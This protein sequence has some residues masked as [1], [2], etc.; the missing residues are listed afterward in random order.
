MPAGQALVEN[1]ARFLECGL[2]LLVHILEMTRRCSAPNAVPL[3][4]SAT[5]LDIG[6]LLA[7]PLG[8]I[9]NGY[10]LAIVV[11]IDQDFLAAMILRDRGE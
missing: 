3:C 11:S 6:G 1:T 4:S 8:L 9:R 2:L 10:L 5:D 7:S